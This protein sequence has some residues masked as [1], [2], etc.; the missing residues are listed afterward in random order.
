MRLQ[1]PFYILVAQQVF[2]F[3]AYLNRHFDNKFQRYTFLPGCLILSARKFPSCINYRERIFGG[4][5]QGLL[6]LYHNE[7]VCWTWLSGK[8]IDLQVQVLKVRSV[9][10]HVSEANIDASKLIQES[11]GGEGTYR[12]G[13]WI[14]LYIHFFLTGLL[15]MFIFTTEMRQ[16][17]LT[18]CRVWAYST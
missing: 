13:P 16:D 2:E 6:E 5:T 18:S 1:I 9:L 12:G 17:P 14:L 11:G 15:N 10:L 3:I 4:K 8:N 7:T